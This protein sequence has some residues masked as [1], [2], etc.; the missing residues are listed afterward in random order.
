MVVKEDVFFLLQPFFA[1]KGCT[2]V[3]DY[4]ITTIFRIFGQKWSFFGFRLNF[5]VLFTTNYFRGIN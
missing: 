5:D 3:N 1:K 4:L 2:L